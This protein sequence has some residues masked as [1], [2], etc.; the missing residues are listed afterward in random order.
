[1]VSFR[2]KEISN[3]PKIGERLKD[4]R[5]YLNKTIEDVSREI[6]ISTR[7]LSALENGEYEKIPGE[8][9]AKSFLKVYAKYLGLETNVLM[10]Y[11]D[12][13]QKIYSKTKTQNNIDHKKPVERVSRLNLI[14]TPKIIRSAAIILLAVICL[15]YLGL[16][17]KAIM[18][19]PEIEVT[20]PA[21]DMAIEQNYITVAGKIGSETT[22][23]INGQKVMVDAKGNFSETLE[24]QSGTNT[25]E[26]KVITRHGK[27]KKLFRQII[28]NK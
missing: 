7:Y 1:M 3:P 10:S 16:K 22:L 27:E 15:L 20:S 17:V 23:E 9:Y 14:A 13:E 21:T 19:L 12:S 24:L 8:V 6:N 11:F 5:E 26:F 25:V 2:T 28:V 4:Q 18:A